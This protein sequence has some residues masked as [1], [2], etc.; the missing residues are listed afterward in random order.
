[1]TE[2]T[3]RVARLEGASEHL[4][5]KADIQDLNANLTEKISTV[6]KEIAQLKGSAKTLATGISVGLVVVQLIL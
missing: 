6:E 5:T 2:L 1:M 4:A 3:E